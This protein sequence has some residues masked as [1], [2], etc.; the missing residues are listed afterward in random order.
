MKLRKKIY[1][2]RIL[3]LLALGGP[4]SIA[5]SHADSFA[6]WN[7]IRINYEFIRNL[8]FVGYVEYRSKDDLRQTDRWTLSGMLDYKL[9]PY[10]SAEGGY[11]FHYRYK[12]K[13]NWGTRNR[14]KLGLTGTLKW[15]N[16]KLSLRERLQRTVADGVTEDRLRSRIKFSYSPERL[17][18]SPYFSAELFQPLDD[19][20][21]FTASRVR[22][23]PGIVVGLS[24]H[25]S[26]DFFYCRQY[27]PKECRN[28]FGIEFGLK[29]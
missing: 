3:V 19:D 4:V 16:M 20:A 28:I 26:L 15:R 21:F 7:G 27:E 23:R 25:C 5:E 14:Y 10:L 6:T 18:F 1:L 13:G 11:A 24:G 17:I 2:I 29:F 9:N 8:K 22:Y 12:G